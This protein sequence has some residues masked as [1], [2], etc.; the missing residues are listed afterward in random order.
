MAGDFENDIDDDNSSSG[1]VAMIL[2]AVCWGCQSWPRGMKEAMAAAAAHLQNWTLQCHMW[3]AMAQ[4]NPFI[5][6]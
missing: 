1:L 5:V 3:R 6:I 2:L 4:L